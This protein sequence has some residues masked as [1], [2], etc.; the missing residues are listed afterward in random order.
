M[1]NGNWKGS[2]SDEISSLDIRISSNG[3]AVATYITSEEND[4]LPITLKGL[5]HI[6]IE[7]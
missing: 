7:M 2:Y 6:D 3:D 1:E 4:R 5:C